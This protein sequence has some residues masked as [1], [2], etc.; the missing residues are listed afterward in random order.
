MVMM[1]MVTR[2]SSQTSV[3]P[4]SFLDFASVVFH[5]SSLAMGNEVGVDRAGVDSLVALVVGPLHGFDLDAIANAGTAA[6]VVD[7]VLVAAALGNVCTAGTGLDRDV[8]IIIIGVLTAADPLLGRIRVNRREGK[9]V[10]PGRSAGRI[11]EGGSFIAR[12][13]IGLFLRRRRR[14]WWRWQSSG[15]RSVVAGIAI[16]NRM[17]GGGFGRGSGMKGRRFGRR[18]RHCRTGSIGILAVATVV[19]LAT[20]SHTGGSA[21]HATA[22]GTALDAVPEW[23][24]VMAVA[25]IRIRCKCSKSIASATIVAA[26]RTGVHATAQSLRIAVPVMESPLTGTRRRHHRLGARRG[27]KALPQFRPIFSPPRALDQFD[28]AQFLDAAIGTGVHE[29]LPTPSEEFF[30]AKANVGVGDAPAFGVVIVGVDGGEGAGEVFFVFFVLGVLEVVI[31]FAMVVVVIVVVAVTIVSNGKGK[32]GGRWRVIRL[33]RG[34]QRV[35][36]GDHFKII[37]LVV[38]GAVH[39]ASVRMMMIIIMVGGISSWERAVHVVVATAIAAIVRSVVVA[40]SSMAHGIGLQLT[41][42]GLK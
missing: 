35:V 28:P 19:A 5:F 40:V 12:F 1:T 31:V 33:G 26:N 42:A 10:I 2:T 18:R 39:A 16:R 20:S 8:I 9:I 3:L 15:R 32:S 22:N 13:V 27:L 23:M 37:E 29:D 14:R 34:E 25:I 38:Q 30:L 11:G 7:N 4:L 21:S 41:Q 6:V 17:K 36:F 24:V